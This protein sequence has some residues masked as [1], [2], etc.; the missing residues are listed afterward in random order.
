MAMA[1]QIRAFKEKYKGRTTAALQQSILEMMDRAQTPQPSVKVTG[2]SFVVGKIPVDS[3]VLWDSLECYVNNQLV[4][5]GRFAHHMAASTIQGGDHFRA[6]WNTPYAKRIEEGFFGMD[7]MGRVYA[8]KGRF[9]V[10]TA[11]MAWDVILSKN[12]RAYG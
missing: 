4:G 7:S 5:T 2:G 3:S 9:Y 8:Q 12:I 6:V 10:T 1:A 11:W